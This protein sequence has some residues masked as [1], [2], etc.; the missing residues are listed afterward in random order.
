[1]SMMCISDSVDLYAMPLL[2]LR[3]MLIVTEFDL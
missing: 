1:M 3:V 2:D